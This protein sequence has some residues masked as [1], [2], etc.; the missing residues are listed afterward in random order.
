MPSDNLLPRAAHLGPKRVRCYFN[1][2]T[3]AGECRRLIN[4]LEISAERF[5]YA[6]E[7]RELSWMSNEV[8][9]ILNKSTRLLHL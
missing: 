2:R 3:L 1:F 4:L 6:F 9:S 8:E 7:F 5:A